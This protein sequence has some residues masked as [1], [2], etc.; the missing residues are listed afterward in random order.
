MK[1]QLF[2]H[3]HNHIPRECVRFVLRRRRGTSSRFGPQ[4]KRTS[5]PLPTPGAHGEWFEK[6]DNFAQI[7]LLPERALDTNHWR[8]FA[9]CSKRVPEFEKTHFSPRKTGLSQHEHT[10]PNTRKFQWLLLCYADSFL[11][12]G[13]KTKRERETNSGKRTTKLWTTELSLEL[14]WRPR[15]SRLKILGK[16]FSNCAAR[17]NERERWMVQNEIDASFLARTTGECRDANQVSILT[18]MAL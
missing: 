14:H 3:K 4:E 17:L 15:H 10:T 18:V 1:H 5:P 11:P 9:H 7:T 2:Q 16:V 13:E 8:H 12:L 6:V